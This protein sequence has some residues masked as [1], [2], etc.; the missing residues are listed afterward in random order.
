VSHSRNKHWDIKVSQMG[1]PKLTREGL[2]AALITLSTA[3]NVSGIEVV[4]LAGEKL[5]V[6]TV[7]S[8]S[9]MP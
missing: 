3:G 9:V 6:Y 1:H 2:K 4:T 5:N 7:L 8:Y